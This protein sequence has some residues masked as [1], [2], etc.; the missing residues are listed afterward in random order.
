[1]RPVGALSTP[2]CVT[3]MVRPATVAVDDR[4]VDCEEAAPERVSE[5]EP[6]PLAGLAEIQVV[7]LDAVHEQPLV[8]ATVSVTLPPAPAIDT[9]VGE[10]V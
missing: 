7:A 5:A 8:V 1:M 6:L 9:V 4:A 2:P 10:T 3:V